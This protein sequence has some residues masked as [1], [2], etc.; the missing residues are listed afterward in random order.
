MYGPRFRVISTVNQP[1]DPGMN[2]GAGTHHAGLDG[3][4]QFAIAQ[5][6]ISNPGSSIAQGHDLRMRAGIV[7]SDIAVPSSADYL[8]LA[9]HYRPNRNLANLKRTLGAAEC[10]FHVEFVGRHNGAGV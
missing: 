3:H 8:S 9:H 10:L 2:Q 6:M 4:E 1:Y 5:A 7:L